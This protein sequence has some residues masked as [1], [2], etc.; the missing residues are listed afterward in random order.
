MGDGPGGY[1][2]QQD[3]VEPVSHMSN[4]FSAVADDLGT[5]D[6]LIMGRMTRWFYRKVSRE[7]VVYTS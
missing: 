5:S 7:S 4:Q 1:R 2:Y 6:F 3:R